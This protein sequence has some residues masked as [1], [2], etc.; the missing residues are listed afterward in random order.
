VVDSAV[1]LVLRTLAV[2]DAR[3]LEVRVVTLELLNRTVE[4]NTGGN[5][6]SICCGS[7]HIRRGFQV[8]CYRQKLYSSCT[9]PVRQHERRGV[10]ERRP[11]QYQRVRS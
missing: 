8:G 6:E 4:L 5:L 1:T 7:N 10:G 2:R 11:W 3:R 9:Q